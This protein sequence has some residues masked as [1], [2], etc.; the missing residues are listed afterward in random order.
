MHAWAFLPLL[1]PQ[2]A[3]PKPVSPSVHAKDDQHAKQ[4]SNVAANSF[5]TRMDGLYAPSTPSHEHSIHVGFHATEHPTECLRV[6]QQAGANVYGKPHTGDSGPLDAQHGALQRSKLQV[7]R[8]RQSTASDVKWRRFCRTVSADL[9]KTHVKLSSNEIP[10]QLLY[11]QTHD[12]KE[13]TPTICACSDLIIRPRSSPQALSVAS[14]VRIFVFFAFKIKPTRAHCR[15][16]SSNSN[17]ISCRDIA[18]I[19][20][21]SARRKS[22]KG[23]IP[24]PKSNPAGPTCALQS[25]MPD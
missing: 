3:M 22:S 16:S 9:H 10:H 23:L 18:K 19:N 8:Q 25:P 24:S 13:E 20:T 5:E 21:S 1:L 11:G 2:V 14:V 4:A 6:A 15:T 12:S 17:D 7:T